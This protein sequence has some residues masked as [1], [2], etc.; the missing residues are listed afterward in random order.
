MG[1]GGGGG[2]GEADW[3][4][5]RD[6]LFPEAVGYQ[7]LKGAGLCQW[8]RDKSAHPCYDR[9]FFI[10]N[11]QSID[12]ESII[13]ITVLKAS[14]LSIDWLSLIHS[15]KLMEPW[16][17]VHH[18]CIVRISL[19]RIEKSRP[20][21]YIQYIHMWLSIQYLVVVYGNYRVTR[22]LFILVMLIIFAC[23]YFQNT[24]DVESE[25]DE[26]DNLYMLTIKAIHR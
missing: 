15:I 18:E 17:K 5:D 13:I 2:W 9:P 24:T 8:K 16:R 4:C 3:V 25:C 22:W 7:R 21:W 14:S 19:M 23:Y 6:G 11:N 26:H 20:L 10:I 12:N 1:G